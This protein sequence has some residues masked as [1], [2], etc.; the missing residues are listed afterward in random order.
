MERFEIVEDILG[1]LDS[2]DRDYKKNLK[3][4]QM[5]IGAFVGMNSF[6]QHMRIMKKLIGLVKRGLLSQV[7][8]ETW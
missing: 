6:G 1:M 5:Q 3:S 4:A 7:V 2:K 8:L